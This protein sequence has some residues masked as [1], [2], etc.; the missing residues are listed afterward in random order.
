MNAV[1]A[2]YQAMGV[3]MIKVKIDYLAERSV[4]DD[5]AAEGTQNFFIGK[6]FKSKL[7]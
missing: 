7:L 4:P 1:Y 6:I 5:V 3:D 2:K